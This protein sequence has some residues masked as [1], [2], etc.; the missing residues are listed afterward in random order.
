MNSPKWL[1]F[2]GDRNIRTTEDAEVYIQEKII[3]Q[4]ERVGFGNYV[5]IRKEDGAKMGA[6]G[7][8][9]RPEMEG[10]DIGFAFLPEFEGQGYGTEA[11]LRIKQAAV[12]DFGIELLK[13]ITIE[14]NVGSRKLLE[15][16][17]LE[18]EKYIRLPN[19]PEELMLYVGDFSQQ[20][21]ND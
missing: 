11:A 8:Y 20:N 4:F 9:D 6:C 2:I 13:A 19:D 10:V 7:L 21:E 15:K 5:V 18:F 1:D 12:D 14:R 16:L 3:S 17:G